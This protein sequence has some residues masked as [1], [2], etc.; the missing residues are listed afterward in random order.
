MEEKLIHC[1]EPHYS[2]KMLLSSEQRLFLVM[3]NQWNKKPWHEFRDGVW[4]SKSW[5][6]ELSRRVMSMGLMV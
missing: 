4:I 1:W 2:A 5:Y 6:Y 3:M